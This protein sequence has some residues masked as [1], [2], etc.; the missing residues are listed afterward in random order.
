MGR[1]SARMNL[2]EGKVSTLLRT[3]TVPMIFGVLGLVAFNMADTYFVGRLGTVQI[4]ALTFTFPVVLVLN[5]LN[6]GIGMGASAVISRAV[7][8]RNNEKVIR[9]STDCLTLGIVI[10]VTAI[11]IGELTIEPLFSSMGAK[12]D[13]MPYIKSYMRIW[14]AGVPLVAIPMIGNNAIRALGDT[15]TPSIVMMIAAVANTV[16]DPLLIFGIWIFPELGVAGAATA[17]VIS[18]M[19]TFTLALYIL[20]IREKV[21][22]VRWV[23]LAPVLQSWR[24]ILFI[25]L[26]NSIARMILPI[27]AGVITRLISGFGVNAVA[28]YGIG[29]RIEFFALAV[30]QALSTVIPVFVGQNFGAKKFGRIK[31]CLHVSRRFSL[32]YGAMVYMLLFVVARPVA[33]LFTRVREVEDVIVLY[34][35]IVPLGY[36]LQGMMLIANGTLNALHRPFQAASINLLQMMAVYVPLAMLGARLF[37]IWGV[38]SALVVSYV[39]VTGYAYILVQRTIGIR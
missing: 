13:T 14:Y 25:G 10:S 23:G 22:S 6:L 39:A 9:L 33:S 7:G 31:E 27:G 36:G 3:L 35:R 11:I 15:K 19:T 34:L 37:G 5:S 18:R 17:T 2:T 28:G 32:V 16:L 1:K 4:A 12:S 8:E 30:I 26:P 24:T 21:I 38:F 20:G 29:T